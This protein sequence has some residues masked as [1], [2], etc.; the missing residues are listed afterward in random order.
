M[1]GQAKVSVDITNTGSRAGEEVVQLYT[2]DPQASVTRPVKELKG[3]KRVALEP[4]QTKTVTFT[5]STNLFGFY[6]QEMDYVVEPGVI[7]VMV[8]NSSADIYLTGQFTLTGE[9]TD[10]SA[11][12][13]FFSKVSVT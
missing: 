5:L 11:S 2:R 1:G 8:G 3:F 4:G 10:V 13:T 9:I 7:E 6:N 12:K